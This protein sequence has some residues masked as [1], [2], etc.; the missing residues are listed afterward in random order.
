MTRAIID[1]ALYNLESV[2]LHQGGMFQTCMS[3]ALQSTHFTLS[4]LIEVDLFGS[5]C[6]S[7]IMGKGI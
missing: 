3:M 5:S 4:A 1:V 2:Y 7:P 6:L